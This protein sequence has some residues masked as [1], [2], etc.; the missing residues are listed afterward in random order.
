MIKTMWFS[1]HLA[2][3]E[4]PFPCHNTGL[5]ATF[6]NRQFTP[7]SPLQAARRARGRERTER[8]KERLQHGRGH[9]VLTFSERDEGANWLWGCAVILSPDSYFHSLLHVSWTH[10]EIMNHIILSS[11]GGDWSL[12]VYWNH[13]PQC[14]LCLSSSSIIFTSALLDNTFATGQKKHKILAS[15]EF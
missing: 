14:R 8:F 12:C 1:D 4:S 15:F 2:A 13:M 5:P 9:F 10:Q 6:W 11:S 7:S 3:L